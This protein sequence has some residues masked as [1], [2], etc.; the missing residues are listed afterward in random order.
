[1]KTGRVLLISSVLLVIVSLRGIAQDR[2]VAKA[3]EEIY[4][5]WVSA[6]LARTQL[7]KYVLGAGIM[8][9]Y[10]LLSDS[11]PLDEAT[12][13]IDAKWTD[14]D[15]NIWYRTHGVQTT[16]TYKDYTYVELDKVNNAGTIWE[17]QF[18]P[19]AYKVE[20]DPAYAP[21]AFDPNSSYHGFQYRYRPEE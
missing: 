4:G 14:S 13:E 16:G 18:F 8:K 10:R 6:N 5:T 1:M 21:K 3:D 12:F 7:Q 19:L 15:G 9:R 17:A 11:T 2:Y 20:I